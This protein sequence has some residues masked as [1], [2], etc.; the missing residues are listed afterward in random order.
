LDRLERHYGQR[1]VV[2]TTPQFYRDAGLHHMKH[3]EF[4]LRSVAKTLDHVYTKQR[5]SFWQ[6][7]GTGIVSGINGDVDLN[8]FAGSRQSW[9]KWVRQ[10]QQ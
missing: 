5:W 7:S 8:A 10:R 6:Y 2:Y 9:A 3:E 1:P 4:W